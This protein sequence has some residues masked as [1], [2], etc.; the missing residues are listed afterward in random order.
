MFE[1]MLFIL[2]WIYWLI[3]CHQTLIS[4]ENDL[5]N[6]ERGKEQQKQTL[7]Y[8]HLKLLFSVV[9]VTQKRHFC[10]WSCLLFSGLEMPLDTIQ[11]DDVWA[12]RS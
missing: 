9:S 5:I 7:L 2:Y 10:H 11:L 8:V 4:R 12:R 3:L 6:I 1:R